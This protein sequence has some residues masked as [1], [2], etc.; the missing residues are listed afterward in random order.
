MFSWAL[1]L[2]EP[3]IG[4]EANEVKPMSHAGELGRAT[5]AADRNKGVLVTLVS[6]ELVEVE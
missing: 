6:Q 5:A 2:L 4:C 1:V 3:I